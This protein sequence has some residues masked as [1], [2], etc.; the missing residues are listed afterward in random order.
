MLRMRRHLLPQLAGSAPDGARSGSAACLG[1]LVA[2][3]GLQLVPFV[4]LVVVP[5]MR[6]T[7]DPM[8]GVRAS[9]TSAFASAVALLPLAQVLLQLRMLV[10]CHHH[11]LSIPSFA[12]PLLL[13]RWG[14]SWDEQLLPYVPLFLPCGYGLPIAIS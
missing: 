12:S 8:P 9:A 11:L 7:S 1:A 13:Q 10:G 6:L 3:L 14:V 2:Q 5:L 4:N